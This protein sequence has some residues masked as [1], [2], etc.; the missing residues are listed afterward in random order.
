M[1]RKSIRWAWRRVCAWRCSGPIVRA[2]RAGAARVRDAVAVGADHVACQM[3]VTAAMRALEACPCWAV[4]G[5]ADTLLPHVDGNDPWTSVAALT[6]VSVIRRAGV[7]HIA[8]VGL[9]LPRADDR[10]ELVVFFDVRTSGVIA[11]GVFRTVRVSLSMPFW[12]LE[13]PR[14]IIRWRQ[15]HNVAAPTSGAGHTRRARS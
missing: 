12:S 7:S 4:E 2:S 6:M 15:D 8:P 11:G 13:I 3:I 5:T 14:D 10:E 9:W 1:I